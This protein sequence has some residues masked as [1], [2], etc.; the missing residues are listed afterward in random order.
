MDALFILENIMMPALYIKNGIELASR[1]LEEFEEDCKQV[2][3]LTTRYTKELVAPLLCEA[4][5]RYPAE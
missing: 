3:T 5:A 4:R 2:L 1:P